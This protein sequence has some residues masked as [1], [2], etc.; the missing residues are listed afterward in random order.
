M[1]PVEKAQVHI[2][3][4]H[5]NRVGQTTTTLCCIETHGGFVVV[6]KSA[7]IDPAKFDEAIGRTCAYDDAINQLVEFDVFATKTGT[8]L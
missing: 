5:Y 4:I 8:K 6:G 1:N 3:Q 2:K 7:C